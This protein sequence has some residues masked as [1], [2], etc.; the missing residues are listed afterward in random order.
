MQLCM[1]G[2]RCTT[3]KRISRSS[4]MLITLQRR[5]IIIL[6]IFLH[7]SVIANGTDRTT[8]EFLV[9]NLSVSK[10]LNCSGT[11]RLHRVNVIMFDGDTNEKI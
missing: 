2:C 9:K 10:Q 3:D 5:M 7:L 6:A 1:P 8:N 11:F 4:E